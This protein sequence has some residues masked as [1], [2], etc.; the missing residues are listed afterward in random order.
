[1]RALEGVRVLDFTWVAAGPA[2]SKLLA[3]NGAEVI[4]VESVQRPD[5]TRLLEPRRGDAES[6]NV[7]LYFNNM[8][9]DKLSLALDLNQPRGLAL[10][11]RLV[12]V[13]DIVM[14][15][16]SPRA[17]EKW[18]LDYASLVQFKRDIIVVHMPLMG[19]TGPNKHFAG[20]GSGLK[21]ISGL[22][23]VMGFEGTVPVGPQGTYPDFGINPAHAVTACLAALHYRYRTG[24]G[25][26]IDLSQYESV[27]N[28]TGTAVLEYLVNGRV[29]PRRGNQHPTM[30][31]HGVY[32]CQGEDRWLA[33]AVEDD[34]AWRRLCTTARQ[35]AWLED[36]RFATLLGR[37][38]HADELDRLIGA[39]TV[40][41]AAESLAAELQAARVAAYPVLS[42][43]DLFE[44]DAQLRSREHYIWVDH[45]EIGRAPVDAAGFRFQSLSSR[46]CRPAP[47]L[48]E[49]SDYVLQDVLGLGEDEVNELMLEGIVGLD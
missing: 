38:E 11:Q 47:R 10:A 37:R 20:F 44:H 9:T 42:V 4:K 32:A 16:F 34:P 31:P 1:M 14:S 40:S 36:W 30:A 24:K 35:S 2:A 45:T 22:S 21:G 17:V 5:L 23:A 12:G 46:P 3:A 48:G 39:W 6:L 49:H 26:S 7:S 41:H 29:P 27:I 43:E 8:N 28:A 25:Q 13:S 19:L 15:N 18:G 33:L